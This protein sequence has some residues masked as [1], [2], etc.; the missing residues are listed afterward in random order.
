MSAAIQN[1]TQNGAVDRI[2][3]DISKLCQSMATSNTDIP[4]FHGKP[5]EDG[6]KWLS[7]YER[8]TA[9]WLESYRMKR[10]QSFMTGT[11]QYWIQDLQKQHQL[12]EMT[13][14]KFKKLFIAKFVDKDYR[15]IALRK[16]K[17]MKF[18][19]EDHKV[20]T[21]IVDFKHWYDKLFPEATIQFK[22]RELFERFPQKFQRK[23]LNMTSL[24]ALKSIDEFEDVAVR[25]EQCMRL[26]E[27]E[28][29]K[30]MA[31]KAEMK[32]DTTSRSD[33]LL[34]ELVREIREISQSFKTFQN[35]HSRGSSGRRCFK[36]TGP[37]PNC[38]CSSVCRICKGSYPSCGCR[39][40]KTNPAIK[41]EQ[42]NDNGSR[43]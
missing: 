27:R 21:F 24:E 26:K 29:S 11:A 31:V 22:I 7:L 30:L 9:T 32:A 17:G 15:N 40:S 43:V 33:V 42:G 39:R 25:V 20:T 6:L 10:L 35:S 23:M 41:V 19:L 36:C 38:G 13:F 12:E 4:D 1:I 14:E 18:S 5:E 2:A 8:R 16:L 28:V 34:E 3:A 37:W